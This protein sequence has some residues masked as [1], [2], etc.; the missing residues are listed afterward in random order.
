MRIINRK[1]TGCIEVV[2]GR[3]ID[4]NGI[5][6]DFSKWLMNGSI[7]E[8]PPRPGRDFSLWM[9]YDDRGKLIRTKDWGK[10]EGAPVYP[11]CVKVR[12]GKT[13]YVEVG[14]QRRKDGTFYGFVTERFSDRA[15]RQREAYERSPLHKRIS[16]LKQCPEWDSLCYGIHLPDETKAAYKA[17]I[18]EACS[19]RYKDFEFVRDEI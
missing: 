16:E 8:L 14:Y 11:D 7:L 6:R 15:T 4:E 2:N 10:N 9:I 12:F 13:G 18:D 1:G 5:E 17:A 3:G 19:G